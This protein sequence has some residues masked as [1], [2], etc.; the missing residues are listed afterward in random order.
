MTGPVRFLKP[1]RS[2]YYRTKQRKKAVN[3]SSFRKVHGKESGLLYAGLLTPSTPMG[4]VHFR[5]A[6]F[7]KV[8]PSTF[9]RRSGDQTSPADCDV[10]YYLNP[11]SQV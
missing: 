11:S 3:F 1:D 10:C 4:T 7:P 6:P 9:F 8:A 5:M 2:F